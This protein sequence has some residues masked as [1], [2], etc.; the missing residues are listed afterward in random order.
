M[1]TA[2]QGTLMDFQ[3]VLSRRRM[4][5]HYLPQPV[6]VAVLSEIVQAGLRA[7]SAGFTQGQS[8]VVVTD[9][10]RRVAI[11]N[12]AG[13]SDY[14][15]RGFEPWLSSAP[16]HL[17][18]CVSENA[19]RDR[20]READKSGTDGSDLDWPVPYWWV[21]AGATLMSILLA[22][23]DAGLAAGFLGAHAVPGLAVFLG[24]P[25]DVELIGLVTVGHPAPD[26]RSSSLDRGRRPSTDTTHW[27]RWG[28]APTGTTR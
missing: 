12:L 21:D 9:H 13:E 25:P 24:L 20:Y 1:D 19:Y 18:V 4:V 10:D 15:A 3:Q 16:A 27:Q 28:G 5:R 22:T 26:R 14:T 2:A 7:P 6:P 8:V 17:V 11:A 23:V